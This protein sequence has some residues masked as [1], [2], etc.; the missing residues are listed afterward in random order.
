MA[1][2][3]PDAGAAA[4]PPLTVI[5]GRPPSLGDR[6]AELWRYRELAWLLTWRSIAVRYKQTLFGVAW[7]VLQPLLSSGVF[8]I[9][10][11]YFTGVPS[12]GRPYFLFSFTGML[13]WTFFQT[14]VGS[15]AQSLVAN[16]SMVT[17]V[18]FPRLLVPITTVSAAGVD[19][20]VNLVALQLILLAY[21]IHPSLALA[22]TPVAL[23]LLA[24]LAA[25]LGAG[26]AALNVRFR[27]VRFTVPFLLQLV[28]FASP[29]VYPLSVV[30]EAYRPWMLLN[31]LV[32]ILETFRASVL[33][34]SVPL[35]ALAASA[36]STCV[37]AALGVT[38]FFRLERDFA[39]L[40]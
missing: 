24:A 34:G 22:W 4:A 32:G 18:Y 27:D 23:A 26:I 2:A 29:V 17:K 10:L 20:A 38:V 28:M 12:D 19:L 21:G 36:A 11:G 14:A 33:G 3:G 6:L 13:L 30:P 35:D 9:F 25:G 7:A 40:I 31:P 1:T 5:D 16:Q 15:S 39:D 8:T 37:V